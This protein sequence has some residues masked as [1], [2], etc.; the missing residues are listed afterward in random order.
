[1]EVINLCNIFFSVCYKKLSAFIQICID[2][3]YPIQ[4]MEDEMTYRHTHLTEVQT[5]SNEL[6]EAGNFGAEQIEQRNNEISSQWSSLIDL[7]TYRKKRLN[8]AVDFY[9]V[10]HILKLLIVIQT[11]QI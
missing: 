10:R 7:A 11:L 9:Q 6:I 2:F 5:A 3:L 8:E 1:M 4:G